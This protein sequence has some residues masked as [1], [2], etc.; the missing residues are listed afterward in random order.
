MIKEKIHNILQSI[1]T[2]TVILESVQPTQELIR[3]NVSVASFQ[4]PNNQKS[5][6]ESFAKAKL[7][8]LEE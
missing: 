6:L 7:D 3:D 2:H 8:E 4:V 1:N 5:Y